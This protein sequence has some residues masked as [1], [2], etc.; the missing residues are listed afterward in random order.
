[1]I[2]NLRIKKTMKQEKKELPSLRK[3]TVYRRQK[4]E[5]KS[6]RRREKLE[7]EKQTKL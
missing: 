7:N 6:E 4:S 2:W 5:N 3:E 1:M